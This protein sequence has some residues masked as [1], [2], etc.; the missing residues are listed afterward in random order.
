M[1]NQYKEITLNGLWKQNSGVVQL[2]GMCP[3]LAVTTTAVNGLSLGLATAIVMALSNGSVS[4]VRQF[5]PSE[6][7][8][9]IHI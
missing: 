6:I 5:V 7:L 8:S 9:L 1:S 2:L 3:T 4:P